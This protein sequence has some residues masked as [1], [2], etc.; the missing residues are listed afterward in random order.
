M[1]FALQHLLQNSWGVALRSGLFCFLLS[2][3]VFVRPP[4]AGQL[5]TRP[6]LSFPHRQDLSSCFRILIPS[7]KGTW[8]HKTKAVAA[9][10]PLLGPKPRFCLAPQVAMWPC[11]LAPADPTDRYSEDQGWSGAVP[12]GAAHGRLV[13][14]NAVGS[15][16]TLQLPWPPL[17]SPPHSE[18]MWRSAAWGAA[19][20]AVEPSLWAG[21]QSR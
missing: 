20:G 11:V 18:G 5:P 10:L 6:I 15:S 7:S 13:P 1:L 17:P 9:L 8:K 3:L 16:S 4:H 21:A 12:P 19:R 2:G 14:G